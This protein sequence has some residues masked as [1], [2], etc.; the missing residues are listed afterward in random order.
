M[1]RNQKHH[2]VFS[3][4]D[5]FHIVLHCDKLWN[6]CD[7]VR[8]LDLKYYRHL[9][10]SGS[11]HVMHSDAHVL[12]LWFPNVTVTYEIKMSCVRCFSSHIKVCMHMKTRCLLSHLQS[13][14]HSLDVNISHFKVSGTGKAEKVFYHLWMLRYTSLLL[15]P[16]G[17]SISFYL[18]FLY[19]SL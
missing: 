7:M 17:C 5:R 11:L 1:L 4:K 9:W 13:R 19:L 14:C 3:E 12:F 6:K 8:K 15:N 18:T 10:I 16:S 2:I